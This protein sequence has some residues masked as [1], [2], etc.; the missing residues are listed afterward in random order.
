M[1]LS[2]SVVDDVILDAVIFDQKVAKQDT[3]QLGAFGQ[4]FFRTDH[5]SWLHFYIIVFVIKFV[6]I[7]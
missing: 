2:A 6:M 3:L 7:V 1:Q 5:F 4:F